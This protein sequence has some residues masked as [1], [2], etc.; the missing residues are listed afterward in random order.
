MRKEPLN[1]RMK[2]FL[3]AAPQTNQRYVGGIAMTSLGH[4][5]NIILFVTFVGGVFTF[6]SLIARKAL[7]LIL[8]LWFGICGIIF[9][10]VPF[11]LPNLWLIPPEETS[12]IY[13]Y[14]AACVVWFAGMLLFSAYYAARSALAR[15]ALK[16]YPPCDNA[17]INRICSDCAAASGLKKAPPLF[18]GSLNEPACVLTGPRPAIILNSS[19]AARLTDRELKII[20]CH[21]VTH[22]KR[23]H[24]LYRPVFDIVS[25][26]HWF[27]P[28]VWIARNDFAEHC[29]IDCDKSALS[30]LKDSVSGHDYA[31]AMLR[32]ME[33]SSVHGG[34][35][36]KGAEALGFI[37]AGRRMSHILK[38]PSKYRLIAGRV[39]LLLLLVF[40]IILSA[41]ASRG[42]FYP[43][44]AHS[45]A[46]EYSEDYLYG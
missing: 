40:T 39:V 31:A 43:Y 12:W 18:F 36:G 25:I 30:V 3:H 22:I 21:E 4:L 29:E 27:N 16:R 41:C 10:L 7:H 23:K 42:H 13:G 26:L 17:R 9:Y 19:I 37:L 24:H 45:G 6:L 15:C 20:L 35:N 2:I 32:L 44:P 14:R 8:P 38:Q 5:F 11:I 28:L 1:F 34:Q 33:L 46:V